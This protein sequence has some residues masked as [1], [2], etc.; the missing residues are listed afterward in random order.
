MGKEKIWLLVNCVIFAIGISDEL[1]GN[2]YGPCYFVLEYPSVSLTVLSIQATVSTLVITIIS[3]M[4]NKMDKSCYGVAQN[5]F[6][7]NIKPW[8][9]KQ[10][11]I[12][13][14]ELILIGSSVVL[15][16]F[17]CYNVVIAVFAVSLYLVYISVS[18][19]YE[20]F[21]GTEK[22][23]DEIREY[24]SYNSSYDGSQALGEKTQNKVVTYSSKKTNSA[25][26]LFNL[27][28]QWKNEIDEQSDNELLNLGVGHV[29]W[30]SC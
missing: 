14:I 20:V 25:Q 30:L 21:S 16:I 2:F 29:S 10:K 12:I 3:L 11:R 9:F 1:F 8:F 26:K 27:I 23:K 24:V 15:H 22:L 7:L 18:E 13:I 4:T 28:D 17:R 19:V 5:D 6:L